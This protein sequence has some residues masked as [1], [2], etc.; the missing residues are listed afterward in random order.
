MGTNR[1]LKPGE[2][3]DIARKWLAT[4]QGA[5][6]DSAPSTVARIVIQHI[7]P[8]QVSDEH[9]RARIGAKEGEPVCRTQVDAG[10]RSLYATG[11][12]SNVRV[13]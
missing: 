8:A 7:G 12:F 4:Q 9:L 11:L 1:A 2:L 13:A 10:V 3:E 5:P 6:T